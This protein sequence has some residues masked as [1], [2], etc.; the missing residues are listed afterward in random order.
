MFILLPCLIRVYYKRFL[1]Y[2]LECWGVLYFKFRYRCISCVERFHSVSQQM[3]S[4]YNYFIHFLYM[5]NIICCD[6]RHFIEFRL[7]SIMAFPDVSAGYWLHDCRRYMFLSMIFFLIG[8]CKCD[9]MVVRLNVVRHESAYLLIQS[10]SRKV[11]F[12]DSLW[13]TNSGCEHS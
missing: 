5:K 1:D 13:R 10:R 12:W 3:F 9:K 8:S 2:L 11:A 6:E 7:L 4:M